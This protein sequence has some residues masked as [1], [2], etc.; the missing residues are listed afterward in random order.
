MVQ[1]GVKWRFKSEI[2]QMQPN[3]WQALYYKKDLN[4]TILWC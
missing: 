3:A 2:S 1:R 4:S